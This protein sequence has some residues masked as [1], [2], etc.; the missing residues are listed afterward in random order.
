MKP[1]DTLYQSS[2]AG[3]IKNKVK[4]PQQKSFT[5]YSGASFF[6]PTYSGTGAV[7]QG[8]AGMSGGV[9]ACIHPL[10]R[11]INEVN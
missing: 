4:L 1:D 6:S 9:K 3:T 5:F 11:A 10:E 2:S 7:P 8:Y